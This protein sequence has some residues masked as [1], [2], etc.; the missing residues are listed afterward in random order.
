VDPETLHCQPGEVHRL[1][2][3]LTIPPNGFVF[4]N[5]GRL[6]PQKGQEY[7]LQ[8][9][10]QVSAAVPNVFLAIAGEGPAE[11]RLK[12]MANELG[13][14]DQVRFLGRRSDVGACLE[15]ADVFV[16][17]SLF[18]G[19]PLALVEAM[20]KKLPCIVSRIET[21][22]EVINDQDSGLLVAP[23]SVDELAAAMIELYTN[24]ERRNILS[25][26][27]GEVAAA[28]FHRRVTV[29]QWENLYARIMREQSKSLV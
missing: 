5:V 8:A 4:L 20:F 18:E 16:F 28:R 24:P 1:R 14:V 27:A 10:Q 15:M 3:S 19:L 23:G 22:L 12:E 6:D 7:F 29:P 2:E 21:L 13:I 17:P 25:A 11:K 26:R 9:F